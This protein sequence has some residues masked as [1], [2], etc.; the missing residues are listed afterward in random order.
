ML[1]TAYVR[2]DRIRQ[3]QQLIDKL[4]RDREETPEAKLLSGTTKFHMADFAGALVD[5]ARAV[6]LNAAL[7]AAN[8]YH[9][10]ALMATGDTSG[11]AKAFEAEIARNP[12]DYEAHLNL[13][14]IRKQD[15]EYDAALTHLN[16]SLRLRP[17]DM[18]SRYQLATIWFAQNR[19]A[20]ARQEL[21]A[22]VREA[23][24]FT[25]A[26]V[27]LATVYYRLKLKALGD[28]ERQLV[29]ALNAEAQD[30]QPKG[31]PIAPLATPGSK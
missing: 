29:Q 17:G 20:E 3:G 30:K 27:T 5:L 11:A 21:E 13:G 24:K 4:F 25:E 23:P 19:S 26:H 22:I 18:R 9:G 6:E 12:N 7:P 16:K 14:V 2:D 31:E 8:T 15:K 10:M 1:G 28:K